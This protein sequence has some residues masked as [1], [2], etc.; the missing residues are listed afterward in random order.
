M[1]EETRRVSTLVH[2]WLCFFCELTNFHG[3]K[4]YVITP[5][6]GTRILFV[7]YVL[8]SFLFQSIL[9]FFSLIYSQT[10]LLYLQ[11]MALLRF[12]LLPFPVA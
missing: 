10:A 3:M 2:N 12:F 9:L 8:V 11:Q 7:F 4:W 5:N 1:S 6:I